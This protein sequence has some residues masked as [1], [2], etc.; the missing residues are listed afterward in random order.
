M[1][2]TIS[3][4]ALTYALAALN[5]NGSGSGGGSGTVSVKITDTITLPSG[6]KAKVV[7]LG[8]DTEVLL[9]FYIPQG[10][11]GSQWYISSQTPGTNVENAKNGDLILY[12][13]GDIYKI[14]DNI[15]IFQ[16]INIIGQDGFSPKIEEKINTDSEYVLTITNKDGSFDTP[17]LKCFLEDG[18]IIDGG[19]VE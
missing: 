3:Y 6:E 11:D 12:T 8:N 7:N 14:I 4:T 13:T 9:Q 5:A 16:D 1:S 17:N 2:Q 19:I 10:L 18:M 15:P